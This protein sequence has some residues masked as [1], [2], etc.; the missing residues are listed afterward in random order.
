MKQ[1]EQLRDAVLLEHT[2][3]KQAELEAEK[4]AEQLGHL[5]AQMREQTQAVL[6]LKQDKQ[7]NQENANRYGC[8][9]SR[10]RERTSSGGLS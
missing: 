1:V 10:G 2:R 3:L 4:W 7:T 8:M 5:Q 9:T 6:R